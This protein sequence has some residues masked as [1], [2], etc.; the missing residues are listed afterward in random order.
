MKPIA[1]LLFLSLFLPLGAAAQESDL[2]LKR[3]YEASY[4][5]LE[6]QID[7]AKTTATLDS[8]LSQ[9]AALQSQYS[10]RSAFLDKALYPDDF[11]SSVRKIRER[12]SLTYERVW[13]IQSQGIAIK[14]YEARIA[15][16]ESRI[17]TITGENRQLLSDLQSER[18]A[19]KEL[20]EKSRRLI[21]ALE[22]RDRLIF[23][24]VDTIFLPYDKDLGQVS[25]IQKEAITR[26]LLKSNVV[27]RIYDLAADNV[28]F[29]DVTQFQGK[30]FKNLLDEYEQFK[31]RWT[32]LRDKLNA[33]ALSMEPSPPSPAAGTA[34]GARPG[35]GAAAGRKTSAQQSPPAEPLPG[36]HV[37]S[38]LAQW[39]AKLITSLWS[40]IDKEFSSK[41]ITLTPFSDGK[42][43]VTAV[44]AYVDSAKADG[45]NTSVFVDDVWKERIDKDWRDI[46]EREDVLGKVEYASLDKLV[47]ELGEKRFDIKFVL[48]VVL[49]AAVAILIWWTFTRKPRPGKPQSA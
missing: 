17:D 33:V 11:A 14:E 38:T 5:A 7:S 35:K 34:A 39:E 20:R 16:L 47:S 22:A 21:Q 44:R 2:E 1:I 8:L 3:T 15:A 13:L 40:G 4:L 37:D 32:G 26:K 6:E 36:V 42:G 43:F 29:L 31:G 41:G 25:D 24:L 23:A 27:A 49:A 10:R 19:L 48:Y 46:L 45:R 30:E 28:K 9:I 18:K 12:H